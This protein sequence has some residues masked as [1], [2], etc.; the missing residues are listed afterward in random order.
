MKLM[1]YPPSG[2]S[3]TVQDLLIFL[4]HNDKYEVNTHTKNEP[5]VYTKSCKEPYLSSVYLF[6]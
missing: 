1:T 3:I 5:F 6:G 2:A 4:V